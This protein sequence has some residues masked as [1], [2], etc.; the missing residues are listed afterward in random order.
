MAAGVSKVSCLKLISQTP[1]IVIQFIFAIQKL[2]RVPR[3][4][5]ASKALSRLMKKGLNGRKVDTKKDASASAHED[6][7]GFDRERRRE[8]FQVC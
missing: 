4:S 7:D 1:T 6:G 5:N 3:L 2:F 8:Y